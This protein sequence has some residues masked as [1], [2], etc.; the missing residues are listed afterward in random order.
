MIKKGWEYCTIKSKAFR[1][2]GRKEN[3][4]P[5]RTKGFST[6]LSPYNKLYDALQ[7]I[8]TK[9]YLVYNSTHFKIITDKRNNS[10]QITLTFQAKTDDRPSTAT[11]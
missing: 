4:P 5:G 10:K 3:N 1:T 8:Y 7:V 11:Y 2:A 9:F 6:I